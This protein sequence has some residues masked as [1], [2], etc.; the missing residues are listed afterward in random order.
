MESY[1][2]LNTGG[3]K[4]TFKQKLSAAAKYLPKEIMNKASGMGSN[5]KRNSEVISPMKPEED[6][7]EKNSDD[8]GYEADKQKYNGKSKK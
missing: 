7:R 2:G 8:K 4:Q 6:L 1:F 5:K 3:L